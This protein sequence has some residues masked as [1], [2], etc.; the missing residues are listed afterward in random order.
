MVGSYPWGSVWISD[1]V[2]SRFELFR[3]LNLF[4]DSPP[5][6]N[7]DYSSASI[8]GR[9]YIED[10]ITLREFNREVRAHYATF[11]IKPLK[12]RTHKTL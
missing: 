9:V 4:A 10:C 7:I 3:L 2:S 1:S 8:L 6:G 11:Y 5:K 12:G